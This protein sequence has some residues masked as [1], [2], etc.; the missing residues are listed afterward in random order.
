MALIDIVLSS[1]SLLVAIPLLL[2]A[3]FGL[4][5][6]VWCGVAGFFGVAASALLLSRRRTALVLAPLSI[7]GVVG[8]TSCAA[9][10]ADWTRPTPMLVLWLL[11]AGLRLAHNLLYSTSLWVAWR[12]D[13]LG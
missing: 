2:T 10:W 1:L 6:P 11:L 12:S 5:Q 3:R 9:L 8:S 4:W 7:V 13:V